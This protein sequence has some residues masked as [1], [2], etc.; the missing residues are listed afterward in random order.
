[1]FWNVYLDLSECQVP[2]SNDGVLLQCECPW[3][4]YPRAESVHL[5]KLSMC[6]KCPCAETFACSVQLC[7]ANGWFQR[8]CTDIFMLDSAKSAVNEPV[9][10]SLRDERNIWSELWGLTDL[11]NQGCVVAD[12]SELLTPKDESDN[13]PWQ[14]KLGFQWRSNFCDWSVFWNN[15]ELLEHNCCIKLTFMFY[16]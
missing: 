3:I 8:S 6:W 9:A 4:L 2:S 5:L 12:C 16:S 11:N 7:S 1:M 13:T 15:V 14:W 10:K